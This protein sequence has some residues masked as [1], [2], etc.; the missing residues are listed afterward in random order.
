MFRIGVGVAAALG[1]ISWIVYVWGVLRRPAPESPL[2][3]A[4]SM[5]V[6][7]G[8]EQ[9]IPAWWSSTLWV[10]LGMAAGM[11][12]WVAQRRRW[13]FLAALAWAASVDE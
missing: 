7:L 9:T 6:D 10:L 5:T 1:A 3:L 13:F 8:R 2:W 4:V 12:G 11:V